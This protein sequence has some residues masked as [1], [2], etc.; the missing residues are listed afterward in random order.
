MEGDVLSAD[1]ANNPDSRLAKA[2]LDAVKQW[3]YRPALLNRDPIKVVT[4]ITVKFKHE[5]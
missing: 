1:A 4:T 2:A 5:E 3:H